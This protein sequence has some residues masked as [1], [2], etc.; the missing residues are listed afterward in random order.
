M[1]N[2]G[3]LFSRFLEIFE[4][5]RELWPKLWANYIHIKLKLIVI[6]VYGIYAFFREFWALFC[7]KYIQIKLISI[8][9]F[10]Y[11]L[12]T[13]FGEFLGIIGQIIFA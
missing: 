1:Q 3:N 8:E 4:N 9:I 5:L 6:F 13:I 7:P 11:G 2:F 10:G 12:F